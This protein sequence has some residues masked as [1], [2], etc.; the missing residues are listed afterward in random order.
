MSRCAPQHCFGFALEA[1]DVVLVTAA[2]YAGL[3]YTVLSELKAKHPSLT[4]GPGL[5]ANPLPTTLLS[6]SLGTPSSI[7]L[8]NGPIADT[9]LT[10]QASLHRV[11]VG[12][13]GDIL[14]THEAM[15]QYVSNVFAFLSKLGEWEIK[16]KTIKA[17]SPR[18]P[19]PL[20]GTRDRIPLPHAHLRHALAPHGVLRHPARAGVR[21]I[22]VRNPELERHREQSWTL[23]LRTMEQVLVC[24]E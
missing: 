9:L 18:V 10:V 15:F 13:M 20:R 5:I 23:S 6:S 22:Q 24:D 8:C 4:L 3:R 17:D 16:F 12:A 1:G 14:K 11:I 2:V 19:H 7:A 21:W